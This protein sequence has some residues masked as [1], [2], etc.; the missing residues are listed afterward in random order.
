MRR[1]IFLRILLRGFSE[2]IKK[3]LGKKNIFIFL[4][5]L[6]S[7]HKLIKVAKKRFYEVLRGEKIIRKDF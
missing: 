3:Y 2:E 4:N 5:K 1:G 7:Y 6:F